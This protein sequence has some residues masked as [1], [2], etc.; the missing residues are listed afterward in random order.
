MRDV[1]KDVRKLVQRD[2]ES[3]YDNLLKRLQ[4]SGEIHDTKT[5]FR[6]LQKLGGGR[7][8]GKTRPLPMLN[9]TAGHPAESFQATQKILFDQF[10][11]IEGG[12]LVDQ[13]ELQS[14][15]EGQQEVQAGEWDASL[16]PTVR[17][18]QSVVR[19]MKRGKVPGPNGITT[20][21]VKAGGIAFVHQIL[22]LLSKC[23][24]RCTEPLTWKGGQLIA[25]FKGK[26]D[27][28]E[29]ASY[30]SI[31]ISDTTAKVFLI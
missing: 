27:V 11:R 29:A 20:D 1:E 23:V 5:V 13:Q 2:Q 8:A 10:A 14:V 25:L 7:H 6:E 12:R 24:V 16:V 21:L 26:G 22:P 17:Q 19:K 31:F 18:V 30:R 3:W 9:D 15:H 28:K 4:S